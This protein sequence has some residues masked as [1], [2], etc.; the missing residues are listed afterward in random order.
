MERRILRDFPLTEKSSSSKAER[1]LASVPWFGLRNH[2]EM[3]PP[4]E[5]NSTY[6]DRS[7]V[8]VN[9]RLGYLTFAMYSHRTVT[10]S[11]R[12]WLGQHRFPSPR[13][14]SQALQTPR[15]SPTSRLP[16]KPA[17]GS[18]R[19]ALTRSRENRWISA[20]T[21]QQVDGRP[22]HQPA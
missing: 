14:C 12:R 15:R 22:D 4:A 3:P 8:Q 17:N 21:R 13:G 5:T 18:A 11:D 2:P 1:F 20:T 16:S 6:S 19:T 9:C 7:E 10:R